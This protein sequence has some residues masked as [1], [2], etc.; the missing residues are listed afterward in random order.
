MDNRIPHLFL[1][2]SL[3]AG[4]SSPA[5]ETNTQTVEPADHGRALVNP[6]T[7]WTMHFYSNI[8]TNYGSK[9]KPSDTLDDFPGLSCAYPRVPSSFLEPQ[10]G[11]FNWSLLDTPARQSSV[12]DRQ[13]NFRRSPQNV[14][15]RTEHPAGKVRFVCISRHEGRHT[16]HHPAV[17]KR[18][19]PPLIQ[20]RNHSIVA[21][22]T[23][24]YIKNRPTY[25][26]PVSEPV[27][28]TRPG[29]AGRNFSVPC[30]NPDEV[31]AAPSAFRKNIR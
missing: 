21:V 29:P 23:I 24:K 15:F 20:T 16:G 18:R 5:K 19:R 12:R 4:T 31:P 10:E 13:L 17:R 6:Q 1:I 30:I 22:K 7:G 11:K 25:Q 26:M 14:W 3:L 8:I 9:L 28:I 27:F 2:V